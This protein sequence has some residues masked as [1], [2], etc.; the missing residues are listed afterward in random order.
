MEFEKKIEIYIQDMTERG[1]KKWSS[2][3][4]LYRLFWKLG[5]KVPP[6]IFNSFGKNFVLHGLWFGVFMWFWFL[7]INLFETKYLNLYIIILLTT[8]SA[9]VAGLISGALM[10][11]FFRRKNRKLGMGD[12][13]NYTGSK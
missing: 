5:W 1:W 9:V 8:V 6:P 11:W 4:P 2:S 10:A 3:P 13:E 7:L 12:W